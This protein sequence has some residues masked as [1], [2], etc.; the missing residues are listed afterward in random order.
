MEI[1]L[2][3][4]ETALLKTILSEIK[5]KKRTGELGILHGINR[6]VSTNVVF[7]KEHIAVLD[8]LARKM[9]LQNGINKVDK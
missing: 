2:N 4:S 5:I 9:G 1:K 7:K 6:F 8:E 3:Q